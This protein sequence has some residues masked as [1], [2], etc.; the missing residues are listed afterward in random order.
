MKLFKDS[1]NTIWAFELDGSQD[2]LIKSDM[3]SITKEEA[4][5]IIAQNQKNK[6]DALS[7]VEK[8]QS[9]YPPIVNYL[10]GL[11]KGDTEQMQTYIDACLAVKAKYPKQ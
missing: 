10:D 11:V 4:D 5:V 9:E 3:I 2:D 6:F 8:R 1:N 7:Y